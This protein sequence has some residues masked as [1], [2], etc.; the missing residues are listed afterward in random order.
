MFIFFNDSMLSKHNLENKI[1]S[2]V[3][4]LTTELQLYNCLLAR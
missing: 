2:A 4:F 1:T 3:L